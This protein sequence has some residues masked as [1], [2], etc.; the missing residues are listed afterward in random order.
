MNQVINKSIIGIAFFAALV[1]F[2]SCGREVVYSK[3]HTFANNEWNI[4]DKVEFEMDVRDT[5]SLNDIYFK[6]RHADAYPYNNIFLFVTTSYPDGKVLT[7]TMEIVLANNRGE[8]MGSGAGDI[9]DFEVP[10]K[11]EIRFP[12]AGKYKFQFVQGMREDPLPFMMDLGFE[13]VKSKPKK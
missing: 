5:E 12:Q 11:K 13:I 3:Y 10:V 8:W 1:V 6:I 4:S 2:S 9:F 7:D